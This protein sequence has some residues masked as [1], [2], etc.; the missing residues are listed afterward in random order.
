MLLRSRTRLVVCALVALPW[1]AAAQDVTPVRERP[2]VVYGRGSPPF[3]YL[4]ERGQP[5]RP[6]KT[7]RPAVHAEWARCS[8]ARDRGERQR[9]PLKLIVAWMRGDTMVVVRNWFDELRARAPIS[10]RRAMTRNPS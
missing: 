5:A 6:T 10:N 1:S 7:S 3:E 4:D 8:A 9:G 2:V